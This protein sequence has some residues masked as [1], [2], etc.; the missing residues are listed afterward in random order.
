MGPSGL[1]WVMYHDPFVPLELASFEHS[2]GGL[3]FLFSAAGRR[4]PRRIVDVVV[5]PLDGG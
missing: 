5:P 4:Q 2:A 3:D 1:K